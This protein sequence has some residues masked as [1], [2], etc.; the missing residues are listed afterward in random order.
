[1]KFRR[2]AVVG[3]GV[4]EARRQGRLGIAPPLR[5]NPGSV[6]THGVP[7]IC[8]DHQGC[9]Q[10]RSLST[11]H[12]EGAVQCAQRPNAGLV[13]FNERGLFGNLG[14]E[15]TVQ[16]CV[17]DVVA[18]AGHA[19]LGRAESCFRRSQNA[20][21]VVDEPQP[22]KGRRSGSQR[23]PNP[24]M[25]KQLE[26][27]AEECCR[28]CIDCRSGVRDGWSDHGRAH[29]PSRHGER[30]HQAR[31]TRTCDDYLDRAC[32]PAIGQRNGLFMLGVIRWSLGCW[33]VFHICGC[34]AQSQ[35]VIVKLL[36]GCR[37]SVALRVRVVQNCHMG[38]F[39]LPHPRTFR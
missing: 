5:G 2:N 19:Q 7:A 34:N 35:F 11:R 26:T 10:R 1:M 14:G 6:A 4:P 22:D 21:C 38:A 8:A 31:R 18:E 15:R 25:P 33:C 13:P 28:A 24:Q 16:I 30:R 12:A 32:N 36:I 9:G 39:R 3:S 27:A 29:L 20:A 17:L 23:R 37:L